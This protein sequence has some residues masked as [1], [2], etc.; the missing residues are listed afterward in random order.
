MNEKN[1][2]T[3]CKAERYCIATTTGPIHAIS[4]R[5]RRHTRP[6]FTLPIP[7]NF[8]LFHFRCRHPVSGSQSS[9]GLFKHY[10]SARPQRRADCPIRIFSLNQ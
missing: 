10:V 1:S 4:R 6:W 3:C 8:K 7:S 2:T 5:W 9:F